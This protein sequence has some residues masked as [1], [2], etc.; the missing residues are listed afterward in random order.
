MVVSKVNMYNT[1]NSA[2]IVGSS[3][4]VEIIL[5]NTT[6]SNISAEVDM[7]VPEPSKLPALIT[8]DEADTIRHQTLN[9]T[10]NGSALH[11]EIYPQNASITFTIFVSRVAA[12]NRTFYSDMIELGPDQQ[13]Q[14]YSSWSAH[15]IDIYLYGDNIT[16]GTYY[17]GIQQ[18]KYQ[19]R[20][21]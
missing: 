9:L 3:P 17:L 11:V 6:M 21:T 19:F 7:K 2:A 13:S 18:S 12:P 10:S 4:T 8:P 14:G 15:I 1:D 20:V 16:E 5:R